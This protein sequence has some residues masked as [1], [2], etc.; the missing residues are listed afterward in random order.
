MNRPGT[1]PFGSPI[2]FAKKKSCELRVCVDFRS[3]NNIT[4]KNRYPLP[5]VDDMLDKLSNAKVIS[6][7]DLISG[8]WQVRVKDE[9]I[10]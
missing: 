1:S 9:D 8:Y 7:L 2:L 5:R 6:K 10:A 4:V 3:L